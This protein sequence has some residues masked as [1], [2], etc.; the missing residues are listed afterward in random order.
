MNDRCMC[1]CVS[2]V[3]HIEVMQVRKTK[4]F[5]FRET[6]VDV[7]VIGAVSYGMKLYA[8]NKETTFAIHLKLHHFAIYFQ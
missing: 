8:K 1:V 6:F 2:S 4:I 5:Q 3:S 7:V